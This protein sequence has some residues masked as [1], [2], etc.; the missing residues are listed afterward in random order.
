MSIH[1]GSD[2]YSKMTAISL[3]SARALLPPI[4]DHLRPERVIDIGCGPG[5]WLKTAAD[6]GVA[7]IIGVDGDYVSEESLLIPQSAFLPRDLESEGSLSD[8]PSF[9]LAICLEVA[10]HLP[11]ERAT[12]FVAELVGLAPVILFSAAI[13][14]QGGVNHINEQWP[15]Y[16]AG[17]FS[18]F[19]FHPH[20][21]R[22][23]F[24][25]N[26]EIA[27]YYRQ[28]VQLFVEGSRSAEI[29]VF[30][31]VEPSFLDLVLPETYLAEVTRDRSLR[32]LVGGIPRAVRTAIRRRVPHRAADPPA[33]MSRDVQLPH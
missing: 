24:W 15:S 6:R 18:T 14:F 28:N 10:E 3:R 7:T 31:R 16:W 1:Y 22:D 33:P 8:L 11:P 9:D 26:E 21:I 2:F 19:D 32:E 17:L 25:T 29:D 23:R 20:L 4:L 12:S 30:P 13:P 27:P 5:A